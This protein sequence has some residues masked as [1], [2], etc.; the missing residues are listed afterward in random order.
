MTI[1]FDEIKA[2]L[3]SDP[4][5]KREYDALAPSS[6]P[7]PDR[8]GRERAQQ[9]KHPIQAASSRLTRTLRPRADAIFT[10]ASMENRAIRPR[11]RSLMR[12]C[13]TP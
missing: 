4:E 2:E 6:K 9:Q 13:V 11:S 1:R 7:A 10:S 5:V 3:L 12:G 8:C